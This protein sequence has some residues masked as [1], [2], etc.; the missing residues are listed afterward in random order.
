MKCGHF[1]AKHFKTVDITTKEVND[2]FLNLNLYHKE[3]LNRINPRVTIVTLLREDY[4][5]I[6]LSNLVDIRKICISN[7]YCF[8][9]HTI[10]KIR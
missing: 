10:S 8:L 1:T 6:N 5:Y 2:C 3:P 7:V 4:L 9:T